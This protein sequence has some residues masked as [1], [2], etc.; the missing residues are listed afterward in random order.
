M[1]PTLFQNLTNLPQYQPY[2]GRYQ[3]NGGYL[4]SNDTKKDIKEEEVDKVVV[5]MVEVVAVDEEREIPT[6][7]S[8]AGHMEAVPIG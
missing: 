3:Q 7:P 6:P 4:S 8:T 2:Q 1:Q 5:A